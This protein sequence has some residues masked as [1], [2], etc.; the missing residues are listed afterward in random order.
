MPSL[1]SI[2]DFSGEYQ[3]QVDNATEDKFNFIRDNHETTYIYKLLGVAL[4][5]LFIANLD[6]NGVPTDARFLAIYNAFAEDSDYGII[7]S[8]GM[9]EY[10]KGI[11][12]YY[13]ARNN[14]YIIATGGN[15]VNI[16]QNSE[17]LTDGL[18]LA[19]IYNGS[20]NTADAIQ[21]YICENYDTYPEYK[22]QDLDY[23]IGL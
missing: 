7:Q 15:K 5:K 19:R 10:M 9:K 12:W 22:G 14:P 3:L 1:I 17:Q 21:W 11:I 18:A 2:S 8:K 20:V 6:A 16:D 13:Y 4:G 23:V